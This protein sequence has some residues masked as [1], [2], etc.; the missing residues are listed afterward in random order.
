MDFLKRTFADAKL[1]LQ[2][3]RMLAAASTHP[4]QLSTECLELAEKHPV[5]VLAVLRDNLNYPNAEQSYAYL[6][7]LEKLVDSCSYS[8]H[9]AMARDAT[10]HEKLVNLAVTRA[11]GIGHRRVRRLARLTLLEY[12][13]M[14]ADDR[15]LQSLSQLAGV[16]ER[17][18]GR[19]LMRALE[20]ERKA[21]KFIE[22]R[23]EDI[24]PITPHEWST[25]ASPQRQKPTTWSCHICTY[26]NKA[27]ATKCLTC[28]TPRLTRTATPP[29]VGLT[30]GTVA[31]EEKVFNG[32]VL[33][34]QNGRCANLPILLHDECDGGPVFLHS[35]EECPP[36]N[37]NA[38]ENVAV[39]TEHTA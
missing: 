7:L 25:K 23:P 3:S 12:S 22:P 27:Y 2:V 35:S 15:D 19:K 31:P 8:F 29:P 34:D 20:V 4:K 1:R 39:V 9:T 16:V 18:T 32:T 13:R 11:E 28:R 38:A 14:F 10:L 6:L 30:N 26:M 36:S 24:I 21:V 37:E 5:Q 33:H 17:R